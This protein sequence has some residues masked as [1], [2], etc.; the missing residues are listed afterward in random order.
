MADIITTLHPQNDENTNLYPNIKRANIPNG[1]VSKE[2]IDGNFIDEIDTKF[3][4]VDNTIYNTQQQ[5]HNDD[6]ELNNRIDETND[7]IDTLQGGEPRF[8]DTASNILATTYNR[9]IG[10]ATDTGYWYYWNGTQYVSSGKLYQ[11]TGISD[12]SIT[13]D[14]LKDISI[15]KL[16]EVKMNLFNPND[17]D[18]LQNK[19]MFIYHSEF[20]TTNLS[21]WAVSGYLPVLPYTKVY[22][23]SDGLSNYSSVMYFN[24]SKEPI[25]DYR[26]AQTFNNIGVITIPQ[27]CYYIRISFTLPG[28]S[29]RVIINS[30]NDIVLPFN[31][32]YINLLH[33][34][35]KDVYGAKENLFNPNDSD[36]LQN[37]VMFIYQ[38]AF[39][40]GNM[41]GW[42]VS[43]YMPVSPNDKIY[44]KAEGL[45]N[46]SSVMYFNASKEPIGDYRV[47]Q[48]FDNIGAITIPSNCYYIRISFVY[49][50][51]GNVRVI[52]NST[53]DINI[54]FGKTY[55]PNLTITSEN[56]NAELLSNL[57]LYDHV[58]KVKLDGSGD[59]TNLRSALEATNNYDTYLIE[60]YEGEYDVLSDYTSTEINNADYDPWNIRTHFCGLA[61]DG[62]ITI[63]GIGDKDKIILKG[64]LDPNTYSQGIRSYI[65]TLNLQGNIILENLTITSNYLRYPIHDD[66]KGSANTTTK[67]KNCSIIC[68]NNTAGT[69]QSNAYGMGTNSGKITILE[70]CYLNPNFYEHTNALFDRASETYLINC[71]MERSIDLSDCGS[72]CIDKVYI[73]GCNT[74]AIH[75]DW[76]NNYIETT[77]MKVICDSKIPYFHNEPCDILTAD[78]INIK[79]ETSS[80]ISKGTLIKR[81]GGE[82]FG[83]LDN[84]D[85]FIGIAIQDIN[86]GSYG[87]VQN[88]GYIKLTDISLSASVGD[89]FTINSSNELE[90]TTGSDYVAIC[91]F[92]GYLRLL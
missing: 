12:N 59:Y 92:D 83:V 23:K 3:S 20:A 72:G 62:N 87:K 24:S 14:K 57:G 55:L 38:G 36:I 8:V 7:K 1:A 4:N 6:V 69:G 26:V 82:S 35:L 19:A 41:S 11:S 43:G 34:A 10:V 65:S 91:E 31:Q 49:S 17:S 76:F 86:V 58:F 64:E 30:E 68:Y 85:L 15:D 63:K 78:I 77:S 48:T 74:S 73:N 61:V 89:K 16:L 50:G 40:T 21:G 56:L 81:T 27:N 25:S 88:G 39:A 52:Y 2:K 44:V 70:N 54:N 80:V 46:Y 33:I 47:A 51:I 18:V 67:L 9:G 84:K 45:N 5:L 79:N 90:I 60:V 13:N 29:V 66:F 71:Q 37:K 32:R 53:E 28:T 22:V 75:Y 42:G